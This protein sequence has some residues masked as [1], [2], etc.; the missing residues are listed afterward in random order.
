[1]L[2]VFRGFE[3]TFRQKRCFSNAEMTS[4]YAGAGSGIGVGAGV[5]GDIRPI[6][7]AYFK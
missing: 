3:S 2:R 7:S 4:T 1:M 5:G 6:A